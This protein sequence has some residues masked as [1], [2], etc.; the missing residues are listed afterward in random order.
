[1]TRLGTLDYQSCPNQI[2]RR[3]RESCQGVGE[4]GEEEEGDWF[5]RV[6]EG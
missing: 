4:S 3:E 6:D 5:G 2:E 1:M